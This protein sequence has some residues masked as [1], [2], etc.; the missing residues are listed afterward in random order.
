MVI[1][2]FENFSKENEECAYCNIAVECFD[3]TV[4]RTPPWKKRESMTKMMHEKEVYND[5]RNYM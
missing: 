5:T 3:S 1:Y 4:K 2:C